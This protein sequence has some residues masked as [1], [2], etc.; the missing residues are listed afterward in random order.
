VVKLQLG[1]LG[2]LLAGCV[3]QPTTVDS[4]MRGGADGHV[5]A[6]ASGG[7]FVLRIGIEHLPPDAEAPSDPVPLVESQPRLAPSAPTLH[8]ERRREPDAAHRHTWALSVGDLSAIDDPIARETLHFVQDLV[9]TDIE[10]SRRE[11]TM[12]F[13][14]VHDYDPEGG[15][16]LDSERELL[17]AQ[18][19]WIQ[20]RGPSLMRRPLKRMLRRLPF[21]EQVEV[22]F[23]DLRGDVLPITRGE[24]ADGRSSFGR[25]SMRVRVS[26]LKDPVELAWV[27]AG[28]RVGSSQENGRMSLDL[29]LSDTIRLELRTRYEYATDAEHLR[30]DLAY[31]PSVTTSLHLSIGDDM[32]FLSTSSI[33]S[34]FETPMDG[35]PGLVLYAVHL[36]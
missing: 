4:P 8:S 5:A 26:D 23:A 28:L 19:E 12:P 10:R 29:D 6:L 24:L 21:V 14:G 7:A 2:C 34:L 35:S 20:Q 17:A 15:P 31:R 3:G 1:I 16:L 11:V 30:A 33:Y 25:L 22:D 13:L 18:E 9:D 32:D 36:F 27:V